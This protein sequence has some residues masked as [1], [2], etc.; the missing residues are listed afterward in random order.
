M[1]ISK[2]TLGLKAV[3]ERMVAT[4]GVN[5]GEAQAIIELF[6]AVVEDL[7]LQGFKLRT[8]YLIAGFSLKGNFDK[9]NDHYD[10]RRH[11]LKVSF[12]P[13]SKL[14]RAVR[15]RASLHRQAPHLPQPR[16]LTYLDANSG[17]RDSRLTPGGLGQL[18][19]KWLKY[20][21]ADPQQGLF[22]IAADGSASRAEIVAVN[23]SQQLV[24]Q[25]PVGLAPGLYHLEVRARLS[26]AGLRRG[27]LDTPLMVA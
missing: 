26:Q 7:L 11:Q 9:V 6:F 25:I 13:G 22:F 12:S 3:I 15:T 21:P 17:Q 20:D 2:G 8:A 1:V 10:P 24:F 14:R 19:G 5:P 27:R 18:N 23:T 16:L 4:S